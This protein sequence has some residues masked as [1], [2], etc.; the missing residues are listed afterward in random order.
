MFYDQLGLI[1]PAYLTNMKKELFAAT[2]GPSVTVAQTVAFVFGVYRNGIYQTETID[3]TR[4]GK[5]FTFT[6]ALVNDNV[7]IIYS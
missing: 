1:T 6:D 2:S 4:V 3:Y 5:V 7:E